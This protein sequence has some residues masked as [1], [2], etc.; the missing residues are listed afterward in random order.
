MHACRGAFGSD[1]VIPSNALLGRLQPSFATTLRCTVRFRWTSSRRICRCW[2]RRCPRRLLRPR[3]ATGRLDAP[4]EYFY[5]SR[6]RQ[7]RLVYNGTTG[8]SPPNELEVPT[9]TNLIE[10]RG[11]LDAPVAKV[12]LRGLT[13]RDTRPSY[14][15]PH[16]VPSGGDWAL[17]RNGAVFLQGYVLPDGRPSPYD[18]PHPSLPTLAMVAQRSR[19]PVLSLSPCAYA[20]ASCDMLLPASTTDAIIEGCT[21][22]HLDSNAIFLSGYSRR[23]VIRG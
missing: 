17:E 23:A 22:T 12:S 18:Q 15:E 16:G 13:F 11:S 2:A 20:C 9:L 21:F 14:M 6:T 7:I 3:C 5:D 10:L 4:N 1:R 8:T 19:H